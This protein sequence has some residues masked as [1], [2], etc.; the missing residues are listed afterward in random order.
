MDTNFDVREHATMRAEPVN[1]VPKTSRKSMGV[2]A[3][4]RGPGKLLV[5][6]TTGHDRP[7]VTA[8]ELLTSRKVQLI[9]LRPFLAEL[10]GDYN[11]SS[12][13]WRLRIAALTESEKIFLI[14]PIESLLPSTDSASERKLCR[15]HEAILCKVSSLFRPD[16]C[17]I[18]LY[19]AADPKRIELQVDTLKVKLRVAHIMSSSLEL[20]SQ[21]WS[22]D[23]VKNIDRKPLD[24]ALLAEIGAMVSSSLNGL[25]IK[26]DATLKDKL[27]QQLT[28]DMAAVLSRRITKFLNELDYIDSRTGLPVPP[29]PRMHYSNRRGDF[30]PMNAPQFLEKVWGDYLDAGLLYTGHLKKVDPSLYNAIVYLARQ[31]ARGKAELLDIEW[32]PKLTLKILFD[33]YR[34]ITEE[35][36]ESPPDSIRASVELLRESIKGQKQHPRDRLGDAAIIEHEQR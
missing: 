22:I 26:S 4:A 28:K 3:R 7:D 10:D 21:I 14:G 19:T 5:I 20:A 9:P 27:A 15:R 33:K 34:L 36:L 13:L 35:Q 25:P 29:H 1:R 16:R 30:L 8:I 2:A 12:R 24:D 23:E 11:R 18:W 32:T 17:N 6:R 31:V